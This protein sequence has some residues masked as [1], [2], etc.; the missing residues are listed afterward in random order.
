LN[1]GLS[2][3]AALYRLDRTNTTAIDP[4]N[5]AVLVQTGSQRSNG[6]ELALNGQLTRAWTISAGA[7]WQDAYIS[8]T[9]AAARQGARVPQVPGQ[10]LSI[11][12]H[13]RLLPRLGVG[14][15]LIQQA[16][17]Y[18]AIDNAVKIPAFA[19]ADA[20]LFYEW[21]ERIRLQANVEN[22]TDRNY[23]LNGHNNN[24]LTPGFARA[25]RVGMS[26]RF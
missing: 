7:A 26:F 22:L 11:W 12:N 6:L 3:T 1:R 17:M 14:L 19:R 18:A 13:Y 9:T 24:N 15:G 4:N 20:A 8:S 25:L 2:L 5:P 23:M 10:T 21:S 16:S